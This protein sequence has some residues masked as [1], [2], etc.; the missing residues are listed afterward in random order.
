MTPELWLGALTS[1]GV[2]LYL[3]H[4]LVHPERY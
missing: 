1:V 3:V 2:A 4:A